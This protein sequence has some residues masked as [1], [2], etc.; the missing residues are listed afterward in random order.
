MSDTLAKAVKGHR[1]WQAKVSNGSNNGRKVRRSPSERISF[2]AQKTKSKAAL[3][4]ITPN[5]A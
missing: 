2:R 3:K 5:V 1:G 4:K